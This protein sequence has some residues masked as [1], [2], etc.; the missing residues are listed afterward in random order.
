[1]LILKPC[2]RGNW[3]PVQLE[4]PGFSDL[5]LLNQRMVI[6]MPNGARRSYW[7]RGVIA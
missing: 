5:T 1:M 3:H 6:E 2:G 7:V 4:M